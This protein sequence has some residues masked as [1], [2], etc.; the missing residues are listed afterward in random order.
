MVP[1]L[2]RGVY[3]MFLGN[4]KDSDMAQSVPKNLE[5][6][7]AKLRRKTKSYKNQFS[8]IPRERRDYYMSSKRR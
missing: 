8:E 1:E 2:G 3:A 7:F 4:T 6:I 5:Q